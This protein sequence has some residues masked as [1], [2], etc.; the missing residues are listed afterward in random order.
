MAQRADAAVS[1]KRLK[2]L[3]NKRLAKL[4]I[5]QNAPSKLRNVGFQYACARN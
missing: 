1:I 2:R 4:E 5:P 3:G